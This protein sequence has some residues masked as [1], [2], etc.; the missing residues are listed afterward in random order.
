MRIVLLGRTGQLG[1]ELERALP[2][3]GAVTAFDR[4]GADLER[5]DVVA[6]LILGLRPDVV[7]N[8]A[9]YT[10]VD[11]AES[12]PDRARLVNATAVAA[13]AEAC[14]RSDALLVH[15]STDY[16]FD[17]TK[18][19]PHTETDSPAP[20]GV[21]GATKLAGEQGLAAAGCRHLVFRTS[22]VYAAHGANFVRTILRL[23]GEREELAVVDD[24]TGAPTSAARIADVTVAALA[25]SARGAGLA[26]GIYHLAPRGAVT[27]C[28]F[29]RHVVEVA[30][31]LGMPLVLEPERVRPIPTSAYPTAARRPANSLLC[32]AKLAAALGRTL[33]A[34]QDDAAPV[35]AALAAGRRG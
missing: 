17:G 2:A 35:L 29:A 23:A 6:D 27:W 26:D 31:G 15:Y 21:Y 10:A 13:L 9:A 14:R 30:R 3:V 20:L 11:R 16:V 32:T 12:E 7:V 8:A 4:A 34:W 5:P 33:P 18:S 1:R 19:G 24:Q 28:G 25:R 22:W